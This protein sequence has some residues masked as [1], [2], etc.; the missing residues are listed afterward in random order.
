MKNISDR[1]VIKTS[2]NSNIRPFRYPDVEI[3]N[4]DKASLL[5]ESTSFSG[6]DLDQRVSSDIKAPTELAL[7]FQRRRF[8][9]SGTFIDAF[10]SF[11]TVE[12][13]DYYEFRVSKVTEE[14]ED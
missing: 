7:D 2:F 11:D 9:Q 14:S 5:P 3:E 4:L 12:G 8:R 6:Q 10:V 13:A 1:K